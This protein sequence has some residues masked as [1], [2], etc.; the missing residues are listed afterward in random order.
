MK[1]FPSWKCYWFYHHLVF[2]VSIECRHGY[3]WTNPIKMYRKTKSLLR[4]V[5]VYCSSLLKLCLAPHIYIYTHVCACVR[6]CVCVCVCVWL[7]R[8]ETLCVA[9]SIFDTFRF[10]SGS[11]DF[12]TERIKKDAVFSPKYFQPNLE[13]SSRERIM[14]WQTQIW[15]MYIYMKRRRKNK[16]VGNLRKKRILFEVKRKNWWE[17]C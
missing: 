17:K 14:K 9:Y 1:N 2:S 8:T 16:W 3:I 7:N 6:A 4:S 11:F 5:R 10:S 13:P 12:W 15:V